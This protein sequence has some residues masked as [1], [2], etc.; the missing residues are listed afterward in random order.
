MEVVRN[1]DKSA[2]NWNTPRVNWEIIQ[3]YIP[4]DKVIWEPFWNETSQSADHL[5]SLGFQVI[6]GN[7]DFYKVKDPLGDI[8]VSNPPWDDKER[9]IA[10]L[11]ELGTPFII[12]LPIHSLCTRFKKTNFKNKLQ[13]I[14]P[15]TRLHFD[16]F[17]EETGEVQTIK[18]TPFDSAYY[19]F[20]LNLPRDLVWL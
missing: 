13:L 18:R 10:R 1:L 12:I 6:S 11:A 17:N 20:G 9:V 2:V 19:C 5:R 8:I 14:I 4:P 15:N 3:D 7:V 16:K